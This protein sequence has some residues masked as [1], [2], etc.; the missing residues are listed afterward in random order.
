MKPH[1]DQRGSTSAGAGKRGHDAPRAHYPL[2]CCA[3]RD[4]ACVHHHYH[5][6]E[7]RAVVVHE[8]GPPPHAPAHGYR[9]HHPQYPDGPRQ[10]SD[11]KILLLHHEVLTTSFATC[12]AMPCHPHGGIRLPVREPSSRD[13]R[14]SGLAEPSRDGD[15]AGPFRLTL[16]LSPETGIPGFFDPEPKPGRVVA[17]SGGIVRQTFRRRPR[18]ADR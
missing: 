11:E 7:P 17:C 9:H 15:R 14:M 13:C 18:T 16:G 4:F 6:D 1:R 8:P 12:A 5:G 3:Y 10:A 2:Q